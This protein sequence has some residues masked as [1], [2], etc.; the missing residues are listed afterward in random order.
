M[1]EKEEGRSN[2]REC[3]VDVWDLGFS[4]L[5]LLLFIFLNKNSIYYKLQLTVFIFQ[6]H[7]DNEANE[8]RF[9]DDGKNEGN[10]SGGLIYFLYPSLLNYWAHSGLNLQRRIWKDGLTGGLTVKANKPANKQPA[11][12]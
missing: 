6:I 2:E 11:S 8:L 7:L 4:F 1:L 10:S 9:D 12:Q 3:N 5:F